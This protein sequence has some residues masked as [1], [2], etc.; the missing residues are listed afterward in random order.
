MNTVAGSG[1]VAG[2]SSVCP[3][4]GE[5]ER[6]D[7]LFRFEN[8]PVQ[9]TVLVRDAETAGSFPSGNMVLHW[10]PACGLAFNAEFDPDLVS[11]GEGYEDSQGHSQTF[12]AFVEG[13]AQDW[14][15]RYDLA[16][17]HILEIGCGGGDFLQLIC[18]KSGGRGT[19]YDP[20]FRPSRADG[21]ADKIDIR[22]EYF[23]PE[24]GA[25][26]ADFIVCRHTLEHIGEI[27]RFLR[28]VRNACSGGSVRLG[29]EVPDLQRILEEGAFWD[30]YYEHA[31]YFTVASLSAAFSLAGFSVLKVEQVYQNQ[32]LLLDAAPAEGTPG[33][34]TR[35]AESDA[36]TAK[37]IAQ[38]TTEVTGRIASWKD[39]FETWQKTGKRI[40]LWGSG[41]KAVG[42]LTALGVPQNVVCVVDINPSRRGAY[43]PGCTMPIVSPADLSEF[44]PD[45]V[46]VMNPIYRNE[47]AADL[48]RLGLE[49]EICTVNDR[50]FKKVLT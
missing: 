46:I 49:P 47:I 11:Y 31:S 40:A 45:I 4:C 14:V 7:A 9:S 1:G 23:A 17:R 24:H 20:A 50:S 22:P 5:A 39:L 6:I 19:G 34:P 2:K 16:G 25:V 21:L 44:S 15:D 26:D 3:S 18:S 13:V 29:F 33:P 27:S 28:M 38:F 41:S 36:K 48:L 12:A 8:I 42:F 43:M 10:C 37:L 35:D 30:I 32:Y